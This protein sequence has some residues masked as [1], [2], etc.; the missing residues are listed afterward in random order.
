MKKTK[1]VAQCVRTTRETDIDLSICLDGGAVQVETGIG[2]FDHMLQ[3]FAV[4]AGFGLTVCCKGDLQ[5]D[6]H[7]TVEDVGIVLGDA[8]AKALGD[9]S[10]ILRY[11]SFYVPMDEALAFCAL[12]VSGRPYL[13]YDARFPQERAGDYDTC[14]TVEFF[15]AV[16]TRA[17]I[18]L[19]IR[20]EYGQNAHHMIEAMFKAFGHA[21]AVAVEKR[22]GVLS[23]K[24]TLA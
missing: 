14:L 15:R 24:G 20:C 9:R 2:F 17:G 23:T 10:G 12:D 6:G 5:V 13:V 16:V 8:I 21:L 1:R 11:G 7:H 4:H 22:E 18:T 3:A 19:H